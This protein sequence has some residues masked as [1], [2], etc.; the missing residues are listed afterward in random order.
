MWADKAGKGGSVP[1]ISCY[2]NL[3]SAESRL[4]KV[5][6]CD[7]DDGYRMVY[8]DIHNEVV[9]EWVSKKTNRDEMTDGRR[10]RGALDTSLPVYQW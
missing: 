6:D 7:D 5:Q 8:H 2:P 1:R 3:R 9:L 10:G 4:Q